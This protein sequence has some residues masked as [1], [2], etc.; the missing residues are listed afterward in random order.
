MEQLTSGVPALDELLDGIRVG[1]NLVVQGGGKAPLAR[2]G[3]QFLDASAR[4]GMTVVHVVAD[5]RTDD[6]VVHDDGVVVVTWPG[7]DPAAPA[8]AREQLDRID[9]EVGPGAAFLFD[10]LT[11]VMDLWGEESA[12]D[13]FLSTC[14]RLYRRQSLAMWLVD[15]TRHRPRFL[16]RLQEITQV[17]VD[18]TAT[19]R[20]VEA[21]VAVAQGRPQGVAGRRVPLEVA[22]DQLVAAGAMTSGRQRLGAV[23]REARVSRGLAQ[24]EVARRIGV[25]PSALSQVERGVRGMSAESLMRIWEA[26]GV[27]FGPQGTHAQG[28]RIARRGAASAT[29]VAT[30][31][32]AR[33]VVAD[34]AMGEMWVVEI[35]PGASGRGPVFDAKA[36]EVATMLEGVLDLEFAG[37]VETLQEG[38]TIVLTRAIP[39]GWANPSPHRTRLVWVLGG[40]DTLHEQAQS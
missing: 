36:A 15:P 39:D 9:A 14:P 21:E 25:T 18:V 19:D 35:E 16:S 12:L 31:L 5:G 11:G 24:A 10:S 17:V 20:S 33:R 37:R 32:H 23:I 1:D 40:G 27:P 2:I 22:N 4:A 34:A 6:V 13:L 7:E 38:D 29:R 28:Y 8:Q 3:R 30:G 26:L